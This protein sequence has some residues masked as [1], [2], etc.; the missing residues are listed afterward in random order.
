MPWPPSR[1]PDRPRA[2]VGAT[3]SEYVSQYALLGTRL[4]RSEHP[5]HLG[6]RERVAEEARVAALAEQL[7]GDPPRERERRAHRA[8]P[9]ADA[10]HAEALELLRRRHAGEGH[11]VQRKMDGADDLCDRVGIGEAGGEEPV[12][13]GSLVRREATDGVGELLRRASLAAE[14]DVGARVHEEPQ[15][16]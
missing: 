3:Y 4:P 16:A 5:I 1:A 15:V 6:V 14:E 7:L 12:R 8:G 2:R 10:R 9:D 13:T 11:D